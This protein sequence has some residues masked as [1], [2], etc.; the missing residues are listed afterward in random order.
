MIAPGKA[1][2]AIYI[3]VVCINYDGN[4]YDAAVLA[5]MA[6]LRNSGWLTSVLT[7][8][9]ARL[10]RA[11]YNDE[12]LSTVCDANETYA[13]PLGRIPLSCSFGLQT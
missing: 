1:A 9:A 8:P 3:D 2:W 10:P 11:T 5:V 12:T 7:N 4:A 6:A 13:L